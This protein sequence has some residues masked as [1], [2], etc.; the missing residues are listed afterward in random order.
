MIHVPAIVRHPATVPAGSEVAAV[1]EGVDL[2]PTVLD[3]VGADIPRSVD[4]ESRWAAVTGSGEAGS[5]GVLVEYATPEGE[6]SKTL[7]TATHKYWVNEQGEEA[8]F[9]RRNDPDEF[10]NRAGDPA[11][12]ADLQDMRNR[13]LLKLINTDNRSPDRIAPY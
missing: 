7:L 9:D 6:S 5:E 1:I 11:C 8:L 2:M 3:A 10:V 4:G 12:V 13:L